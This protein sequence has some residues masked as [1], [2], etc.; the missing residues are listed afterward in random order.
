MN[1]NYP[2]GRTRKAEE[3]REEEEKEERSSWRLFK[4]LLPLCKP[5]R[6]IPC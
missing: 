4:I 5:Q 1:R 6:L 3:P 2:S